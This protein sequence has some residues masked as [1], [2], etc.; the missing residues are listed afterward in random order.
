VL[1][2]LTDLFRG[3]SALEATALL[4]VLSFGG[5]F[6]FEVVLI[7]AARRL[8]RRT[9][10]SYDN[11]VLRKL[12]VP[13]VVTIALGGIWALT[14]VP[15]VTE[16]TVFQPQLVKNFFERPSVAIIVVVWA[17]ALN[18]L[19]NE[20]VEELKTRGSRYNFAPIFSNVW[21]LLV[22]IG[23]GGTLLALYEIDITPLLGAAGIAGVAIGFAA[24][25][26]V[27]N[28][29]GGL[30]LYF[31]DTYK[32]GDYVVLDSGD[33]GTVVNVGVRSTTLMTRDEVLVTVPNSVLNATRIVNESAPQRRKRVRVP[34]G[35]AYGTDLDEFESLV[36][37]VATEES[38]VLDSPKPRM[39]FRRFGDSALEYELLCWVATPTRAAKAT[40]RLN[41]EIYRA[42]ADADIEIPYPKRDVTLQSSGPRGDSPASDGDRGSAPA[43]S[44]RPATAADQDAARHESAGTADGE[45]SRPEAADAGPEGA[46]PTGA[47]AD[48]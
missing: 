43:S 30:A 1:D 19:V 9:E 11:I 40:H 25:D 7:R 10:T 22:T 38:L 47:D 4:L 3:M 12:R 16:S 34:I 36:L 46:R 23:A 6:A 31:D 44:D 2:A 18:Q 8:V 33:A 15:S 20:I 37:D 39:R 35:V 45:A 24:K 42:M 26:T 13:L 14:Q 32:I 27:A 41:R 5:A 17:W 29:F 28:F 48:R 21:T